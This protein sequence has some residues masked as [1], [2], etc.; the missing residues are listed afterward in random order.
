VLARVQLG[1]YGLYSG[2]IEPKGTIMLPRIVLTLVQLVLAWAYAPQVRGLIPFS[3]GAL[4]IFLLAVIIA[5]LVWITGQIGAL[6]LKDTPAPSA[7]NLT[8]CLV[9][10]LV[11]AAVTLVPPVTQAVNALLKGGVRGTAYP[12]IGAVIGYLVRR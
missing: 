7:A 9:L 12:V 6:V 10:A 2:I 3:L 4:D 1:Q 5:V 11:F 8:A